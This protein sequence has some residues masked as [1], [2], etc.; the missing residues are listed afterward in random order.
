MV[1]KP[2]IW[3]YIL[4]QKKMDKVKLHTVKYQNIMFTSKRKI[5]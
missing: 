1:S 2:Q 3:I 4:F 5:N